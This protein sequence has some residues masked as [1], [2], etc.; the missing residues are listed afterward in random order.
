MN[1]Q[2][3]KLTWKILIIICLTI[4]WKLD[5]LAQENPNSSYSPIYIMDSTYYN[6]TTVYV[7]VESYPILITSEKEYKIGELNEFI[8]MNLKYPDNGLE[9]TGKVYISFIV[10]K[11]GCVSNKKIIRKLCPGFDEYSMQI[12]DLMIQWIP[13]KIEND[14]VRTLITVPVVW[15]IE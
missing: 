1:S 10:E 5:I 7:S 13:G 12:V 9:C 14:T 6:D 4:F 8:K 3:M 11:D 15:K 2:P